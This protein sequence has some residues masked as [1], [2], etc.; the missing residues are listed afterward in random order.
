MSNE[1]KFTGKSENYAKFRPTYAK[2]ALL[3]LS[4]IRGKAA[5]IGAGTG[6]FTKLLVEHGFEVLAVEPNPDMRQHLLKIPS[7]TILPHT[8][9]ATGIPTETIDLITVAQ[10][11]HWFDVKSFQKECQRILKRH[12]KVALIWNQRDENSGFFLDYGKINKKHCPLFK[13]FNHEQ[14]LSR[15]TSFYR[16]G[17]FT[18]QAFPNPDF[19]SQEEFIGRALSS[20]YAPRLGEPNYKGFMEDLEGLFKAYQVGGTLEYPNVTTLYLGSV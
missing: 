11:F 1:E 4:K 13:D 2:E 5:D 14:A 16:E 6:I 8:A 7:I 9:E 15:I 19:L 10:A 3:Q 18:V 17:T 20:S 12:G